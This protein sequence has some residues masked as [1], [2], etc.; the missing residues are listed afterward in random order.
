MK[1]VNM[2]IDNGGLGEPDAHSYF[3][4]LPVN[5]SRFPGIFVPAVVVVATVVV[6]G[7]S[8]W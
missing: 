2:G 4:Q 3:G 5:L 1:T 8:H 6:S 7:W